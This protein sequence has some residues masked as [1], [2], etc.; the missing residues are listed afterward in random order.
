MSVL[1]HE[2]NEPEP[3]SCDASMVEGEQGYCPHMSPQGCMLPYGCIWYSDEDNE[4][5]RIEY[6]H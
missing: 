5:E 2:Y 6:E 3:E 1:E 4:Q